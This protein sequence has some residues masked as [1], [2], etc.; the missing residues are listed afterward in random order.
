MTIRT[1]YVYAEN[2]DDQP[3]TYAGETIQPGDTSCVLE[4]TDQD[5]AEDECF[6]I[7]NAGLYLKAAIY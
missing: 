4:T 1:L 5:E 3:V 7:D 2:H 6:R